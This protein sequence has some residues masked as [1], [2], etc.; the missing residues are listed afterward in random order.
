MAQYRKDTNTYLPQEKTLFEVVMLA[1]QYG[2][3]IGPANPS[4]VA[5]DGFGRA[6]V[7]NPV[8]LFDSFHRYKDNEKIGTANSAGTTVIH[9]A[10]S[11]SVVCSVGTANNNYIYRESNRVFAYQPGKSLQIMQSFVLAPAQ[12][13]LRQRY[14]YFGTENGLFLE[15]DGHNIYFVKRSKSNGTVI[16]T[17]VAQSNWNID[18]LDGSNTGPGTDGSPVS[19]RNPS[20]LTLNLSKAQILWHDIEWLGT[21]SVRVGFVINGRLVH[22]HT[23]NHANIIDNTY[24]T[25]GCL[26]IRC[27]IQNTAATTNNSNLRIICATVISEGGYQLNGRPKTAGALPN[28]SYTLATPGV[29]YPV[30]AIRL[31]SE[32]PDAIVVV[33]DVDVLGLT[34]N[35]TRLAYRLVSGATITGGTW[36]DAGAD[37]SVQYN[38]T[39]TSMTGGT[40]LTGGYTYVAQQSGA[41]GTLPKNDFLFQL[42][43]NSLAG[44]NSTY[45]LAVAGYGSNDTCLG[46][47]SWEEVT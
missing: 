17:R 19:N 8:T 9:D 33:K 29:F 41:P 46:S 1:D 11:S 10:N 25:T 47:I 6:R 13:G 5:V 12:T 34:G 4:G 26:P 43:R 2:N 39:G 36:V 45:V 40:Y 42:E 16:E 37:S 38:I 15:Q 44:T 27:E 3:V 23:W 35:G 31:K 32:T 22:C 21:G 7:S 28:T 14:G 30:A 24:M 18:T 20:A